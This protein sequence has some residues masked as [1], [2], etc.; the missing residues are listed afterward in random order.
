VSVVIG[1]RADA[2][3]LPKTD[4]VAT[5]FFDTEKWQVMQGEES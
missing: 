3:E 2:G 1:R 4:G 5:V